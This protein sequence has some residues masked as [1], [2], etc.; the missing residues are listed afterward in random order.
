MKYTEAILVASGLL[1]KC[2]EQDTKDK[3][4]RLHINLHNT[5]D[6]DTGV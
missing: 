4:K 1:L 3:T 5:P 6:T 2:V